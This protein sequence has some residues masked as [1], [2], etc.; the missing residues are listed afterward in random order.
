MPD[1]LTKLVE[2][3]FMFERSILKELQIWDQDNNRKP[4]IIRGA[5]QVGKTTVVNLFA[6]EFDHYLYLDLEKREVAEIF[7]RGLQFEDLIQAI[8]LMKNIPYGHGKTL[9]FLDEIQACP[10]ALRTIRSFYE[11]AKELRV[12][13]AGSL[14]EAMMGQ[15]QISF[16]VGRVRYMF[17]YPL[18]FMEYLRSQGE[19]PLLDLIQTIPLPEYALEKL[20]RLFHQFTLIGGM[21]EI[22]RHWG[23][24][25][26]VVALTPIYQGLITSYQDDVSKYARNSTMVEVI[27]HAIESAPWKRAAG[28]NF[29]G[30]V[31]QITGHGKW[32]RR[33]AH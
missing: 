29:M 13:A 23:E 5:R 15:N 2:K 1:Y 17:M 4:L 24:Y 27:R 26:D 16:P 7:E 21:P 3:H 9:L 25:R 31:N 12:I 14:L 10:A 22:V 8:F 18:T 6:Q 20:F 28:S 19:K 33:C 11:S 32:V 30:L